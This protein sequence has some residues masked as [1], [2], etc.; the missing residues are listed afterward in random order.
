[1]RI[2]VISLL[3]ASLLTA[4]GDSE[5]TTTESMPKAKHDSAMEHAHKH[6]DAKYVC[7]MHPKVVSDEPGKC[8]ICG[9]F[10]V[11]KK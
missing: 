2:F 9:M 4:C 8:P 5:P 11:A 1:M 6:L 10:L 7:P 3:A